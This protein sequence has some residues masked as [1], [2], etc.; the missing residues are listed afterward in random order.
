MMKI[1]NKMIKYNVG[2][3]VR[4]Q[5]LLLAIKLDKTLENKEARL[6]AHQIFLDREGDL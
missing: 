2:N 5:I 3:T 1:K 4:F 6:L